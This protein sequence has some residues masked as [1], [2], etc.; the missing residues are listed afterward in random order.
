MDMSA[1]DLGNYVSENHVVEFEPGRLLTWET[2]RDGK[3]RPGFRWGW[4]IEPA[5]GERSLVTHI[6][7][8]SRV[9]D[10]A[11]LDRVKFPRVSPQEMNTT[12]TRLAAAAAAGPAA[13][14]V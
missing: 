4:I 8:W 7:D 1:P 14:V 10:Q 3:P 12:V 2:T 9:T 11:V 13:G 5:G 6:Y